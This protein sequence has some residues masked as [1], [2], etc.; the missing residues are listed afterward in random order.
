M[1]KIC[2]LVSLAALLLTGMVYGIDRPAPPMIKVLIANNKPG[3]LLEVRGKYKIFDPHTMEHIS[4][5]FVGKRKYL[6]ALT[7]GLKWGEEFPGIFQLLIMPDDP[8]TTTLV[9]GVPY[10]GN[11]Y[12]YDV[13]GM[14]SI[15]NDVEIEK[16]LDSLL[17][18]QNTEN[19]STEA[20]G[21]LA[22]VNRT[23]AYFQANHPKTKYWAVDGK[24]IGYKGYVDPSENVGKALQ[25]TKYMVLTEGDQTFNAEWNESKLPLNVA[26]QL[27]NEGQN[28]AEILKRAFPNT[29]LKVMLTNQ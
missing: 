29:A 10:E 23:Q 4:T 9:D 28:A 12:I 27:A 2:F 11:L 16:Y 15:V 20:L 24:K 21:A 22:I 5:R 17:V 19:L 14:I 8:R 6:Q 25:T 3:I 13:G 1:N 7:N 18:A 26:N